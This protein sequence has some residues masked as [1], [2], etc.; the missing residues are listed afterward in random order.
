MRSRMAGTSIIPPL[1]CRVGQFWRSAASGC[2]KRDESP[3][4]DTS[5]KHHR[6]VLDKLKKINYTTNRKGAACKGQLLPVES[7]RMTARVGSL[8]RSF[9]IIVYLFEDCPR[10]LKGHEDRSA[11]KAKQRNDFSQRHE[12][13]P[14]SRL[15]PEGTIT[16]YPPPEL[17]GRRLTT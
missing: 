9:L 15:R 6:E 17:T 5:I 16:E 2:R 4:A 13:S 11:Q 12:A 10:N 14:L 3:A 1:G 7:I 8:G